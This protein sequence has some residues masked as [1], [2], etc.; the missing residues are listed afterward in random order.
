M[1][2]HILSSVYQQLGKRCTSLC[3]YDYVI[4]NRAHVQVRQ[5]DNS[6][7]EGADTDLDG[8]AAVEDVPP[9][10]VKCIPTAWETIYIS[11]SVW[12]CQHTIMVICRCS[13][14]MPASKR[15]QTQI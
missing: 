3:P 11:V 1:C 4:C 5:A 9:N 7:Q 14:Q 2:L 8:E 15:A 10:T 13:R 12:L 6:Q